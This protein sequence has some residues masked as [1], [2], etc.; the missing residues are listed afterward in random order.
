[1]SSVAKTVQP[2]AK[3][4]KFRTGQLILG[5]LLGIYTLFCLLPVVL[6]FIVAFSSNDSI[7]TKG[8][9]YFPSSFAL[10]GFEY[11]FR[12]GKQLLVSYGVTIT[13][14][15]VGT[16]VGLLFMSMYAYSISRRDFRIR[17]FFAI[18]MIFPM[19]FSGGQMASYVIFTQMY[20]LKDSIWLLILPLSVTTMNVIILRTYVATSVPEELMDSARIDGAGEY[21]TFFQIVLPLMKPAL[22]AVGFMMATAYWNDW[23][24]ALLYIESESKTPLQLLLV[25][26][27]KSIEFLLNSKDISGSA[28]AAMQ[29]NIPQY[30]CIMATVIMVVGPILVVYPFFQKYFIKGLT[31]GSVKG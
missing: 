30:S 11:V 27:Q 28:L 12:Y 14:T 21:R 5:I 2:V 17:K 6:V 10:E 13:V 29:G 4:K 7:T 20:H 23:Q 1:M 8:F 16:F 9:S 15:V 25:R 31:V 22:A 24:N 18:F 26:I 3:K 19:L